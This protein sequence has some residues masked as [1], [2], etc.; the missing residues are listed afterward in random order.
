MV[1]VVL[2]PPRRSSD[3]C[4]HQC[5]VTCNGARSV[6]ACNARWHR[7]VL[8]P[9]PRSPLTQRAAARRSLW[10]ESRHCRVLSLGTVLDL[11]GRQHARRRATYLALTWG[12]CERACGWQQKGG[13]AR[14]G[15]TNY[16][17]KHEVRARND[18]SPSSWVRSPKEDVRESTSS[19]LSS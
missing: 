17:T 19:L 8:T 16:N 15:A 1:T 14:S 10:K 11:R 12:S 5:V 18:N 7:S 9:R 3:S 6:V 13:R 4:A 2:D